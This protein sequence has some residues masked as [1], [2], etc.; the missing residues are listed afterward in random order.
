MSDIKELRNKI[1]EIDKAIAELF[2]K[3]MQLAKEIGEYKKANS[4]PILDSKREEEVISKNLAYIKDE[5]LKAYY[6]ELLKEIMNLSKR[7][8]K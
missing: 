2:E 4:L 8:Q 7:Y 3:R 1:D 5:S 6:E